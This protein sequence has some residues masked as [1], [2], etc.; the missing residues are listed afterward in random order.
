MTSVAL[1]AVGNQKRANAAQICGRFMRSLA[2]QAARQTSLFALWICTLCAAAQSAPLSGQALNSPLIEPIADIAEAE[3]VLH[4]QDARVSEF[5][6]GLVAGLKKRDQLAGLSVAITRSSGDVLLRGFG[7]EKIAT[8]TVTPNPE[9]TLFRLGSTSKLIT[10]L[11]AMQLVEQARLSLDAPV[12]SLLPDALKI[13]DQGFAKPITVRDLLH[14]TAGFEDLAL[15]HL[16]ADKAEAV[17]TLESYLARYRPNRVRAPGEMAVYSNYS[18]ALLGAIVARVSGERFED[19]VEKQIFLP[20]KMTRSSFREPLAAADARKI[21]AE[22]AKLFSEGFSRAQGTFKPQGFEFIAQ[23]APAG[24]MSSTAFDMA[25]FARML[26]NDG[27]LDGVRVIKKSTLEAMRAGCFR[28]GASAQALPDELGVQ[29]ICHGYMTRAY[30]THQAYGHGGATVYFHTAFMTLPS[31]DLAI[32][33]SINT[34]NGRKSASDITDLLVEFLEPTALRA[35]QLRPA[36]AVSAEESAAV[37]GDY[38]SN[39]RP[40][41]GLTG[42]LQS[43]SGEAVAAGPKSLPAGSIV[44]SAGGDSSAL[45]PIA[46]LTYQN[47]ETGSI[48][49][50]LTNSQGKVSGFAN[51]AGHST[52]AKVQGFSNPKVWIVLTGA[53]GVMAIFSL[54]SAYAGW[55]SQRRPAL[56]AVKV[57]SVLAALASLALLALLGWMA[58]DLSADRALFDYPGAS[59]QWFAYAAIALAALAVLKLLC[60]PSVLKSDWMVLA[61]LGFVLCALVLFAWSVSSWSW[62]ILSTNVTEIRD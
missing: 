15:G 17:L 27:E 38:L 45:V 1:T 40:F 23:I 33:V 60:V 12:N 7:I 53:I 44:I 32:F 58:M 54:M 29:A 21:S 16:F 48:V 30:G 52:S 3:P 57:L 4:P 6:D 10:Y 28:N 8:T 42:L 22:Q 13:P 19:Y 5:L 36:V 43:L 20:L 62:G 14:H 18:V 51:P 39:R 34:A 31:L 61:K 35:G 37:R 11:S 9:A 47:Q 46:A 50:F 49:K 56:G 24:G 26:L 59:A 2:K 25:R 41:S 55:G